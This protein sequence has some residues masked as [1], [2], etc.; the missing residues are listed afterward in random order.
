MDVRKKSY[1]EKCGPEKSPPKIAP[2]KKSLIDIKH[3]FV[4]N[5]LV[6]IKDWFTANKLAIFKY[7]KNKILIA[8]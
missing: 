6:N 2:I 3:L 5:K 7:G 8:Q 4:Y 1:L